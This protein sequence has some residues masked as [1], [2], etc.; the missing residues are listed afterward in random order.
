MSKILW[1]Y[2][3]ESRPDPSKSAI[4]LP[5]GAK[6]PPKRLEKWRRWVS[7]PPEFD[8]SRIRPRMPEFGDIVAGRNRKIFAESTQAS[9]VIAACESILAEDPLGLLTNAETVRYWINDGRRAKEIVAL[10]PGENSRLND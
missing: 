8:W 6:I 5:L 2:I 4:F 1:H 10:P 3:F 7:E 9:T